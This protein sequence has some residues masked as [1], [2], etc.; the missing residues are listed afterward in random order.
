MAM[1]SALA[2]GTVTTASNNVVI[3]PINIQHF[4]RFSVTYRSELS[5]A[6]KSIQVQVAT[7]PMGTASAL[8][9]YEMGTATIPA[10]DT[11]G[12][13]ATVVTSA[14]TNAWNWMRIIAHST[15]TAAAVPKLSICLNGPMLK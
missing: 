8:S 2:D 1:I 5:A 11:L 3:N 13:T 9:W 7:Q 15:Q 14:I 10:P 4:E 6:M 12:Q